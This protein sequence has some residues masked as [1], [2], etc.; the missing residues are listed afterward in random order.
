VGTSRFTEVPAAVEGISTSPIDRLPPREA[1][2]L[3][4]AS[5]IGRSFSLP[6]LAEIY[7]VEVDRPFLAE[8]LARLEAAGLAHRDAG[9]P[10][11]RYTCKH[12]LTQEV[13]YGLLPVAQRQ[14]LHRG[15]AQWYERK[16]QDNL[17]LHYPL[18]A[19]HWRG[20]GQHENAGE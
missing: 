9:D 10:E 19:H 3:K 18:L 6:L 12:A 1:L 15:I 20:A 14:P 7:P 17:A 13:A 8:A 5:S 4:V 11:T 2:V 16:H